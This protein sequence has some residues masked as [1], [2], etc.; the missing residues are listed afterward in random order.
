M[1]D[2]FYKNLTYS[3]PEAYYF[4]GYFVFI[5]AIW[6][7][8]PGLL[9]WQSVLMSSRAFKAL[10]KMSKSLQANGHVKKST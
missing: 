7:V 1:F 4:W 8:I 5:N 6:I 9:L 10:D 2:L 3:R